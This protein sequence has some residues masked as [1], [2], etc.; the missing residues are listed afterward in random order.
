MKL[1]GS[2]GQQAL[3]PF[4]DASGTITTGGTPQL[5]LPVHK[6][7]SHL[8]IMNISD[9]AM[10]IE[11]GA[12]RATA[13]LTSGAITSFSVTNAG[14]GYTRP[15]IVHLLGGGNGGNSSFLGVGAPGYPSPGD[16]GYAAARY[17]DMSGQRPAQAH[18][19]LTGPLVGALVIEDPGAG[20][21]KAP[22][23]YLENDPLDPFGAAIPSSTSGLLVQAN[24]G[25]YYVNGTVCPTDQ[26]SIVCATTG[27]AFTVKWCD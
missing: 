27:K 7:R 25:S 17:T 1:V 26:V 12:A 5:L 2:A 4:Y 6:S 18:A 14:F 13:T 24:G 11:F 16:A 20:Y 9:T 22:M 19:T 3:C 15:P 10:Y 23:V 8:L 21:V